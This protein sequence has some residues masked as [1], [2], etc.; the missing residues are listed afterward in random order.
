MP[1]I[2]PHNQPHYNALAVPAIHSS[3]LA[4]AIIA[5][6][7][8][9]SAPIAVVYLAVRQIIEFRLPSRGAVVTA[10]AVS[11]SYA[12]GGSARAHEDPGGP[13]SSQSVPQGD[14]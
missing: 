14:S 4:S 9:M 10:R 11:A 7:V 3:A 5:Y 12:A 2:W 8:P 1:A 6:P 13:P